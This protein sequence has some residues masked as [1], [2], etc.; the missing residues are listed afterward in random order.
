MGLAQ[1]NDRLMS[2]ERALRMTGDWPLAASYE[3]AERSQFDGDGAGP[4]RAEADQW[5]IN[6]RCSSAK[7]WKYGQPPPPAPVA[8][9]QSCGMLADQTGAYVTD[10]ADLMSGVLRHMVTA[11]DYPLSGAGPQ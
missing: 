4:A 11:H 2:P 3:L 1:W 9:G 6:L 7:G 10:I 5:Q 8:C